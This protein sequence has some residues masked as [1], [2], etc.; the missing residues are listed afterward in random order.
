[1]AAEGSEAP[2]TPAGNVTGVGRCDVGADDVIGMGRG[3]MRRGCGVV[4]NGCRRGCGVG[5]DVTGMV[6]WG[7]M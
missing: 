5:D 6:W 4:V 2:S 1:M 3:W 7:E